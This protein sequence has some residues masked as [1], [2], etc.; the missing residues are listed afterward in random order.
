MGTPEAEL[1]R[2]LS[3]DF[4]PLPGVGFTS[5][6]GHPPHPVSGSS[7]SAGKTHCFLEGTVHPRQRVR[8]R[9]QNCCPL[10]CLLAN[11]HVSGPHSTLELEGEWLSL[12]QQDGRA[13]W[14]VLR[15]E[16]GAGGL[17]FPRSQPPSTGTKPIPP[18]PTGQHFQPN[19]LGALPS[20][21]GPS[22][23]ADG[24][25]APRMRTAF[26][27][28]QV[29]ALESSFQHR[30]Y[31]GPLERRRLA[32]EMQLS[33]VQVKTWFQNRRMKHKRQLQDSQLSPP[34]S[35]PLHP[36][37][38]LRSRLQLLC[39]WAS[40]P[41]PPALVQPLGSFWGPRG[42]KPA[43]LASAW[44]SCSRQPPVC[45]LRCAAS[46]TLGAGCTH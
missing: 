28:E 37:P 38:A 45:C 22:K 20:P 5:P 32:Q 26:T 2:R 17:L 31:L 3:E 8:G 42:V 29:S 1:V 30:R 16:A 13:G 46:R 44:A 35:A 23:E 21:S 10:C 6:H 4:G 15:R 11:V 34:F 25:R 39:P 14:A 18:S 19:G 12:T 9:R 40:L 27:A 36:P 43:S 33:E 24:T 41:G 7:L